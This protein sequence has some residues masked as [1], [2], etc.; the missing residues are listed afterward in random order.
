MHTYH[1]LVLLDAMHEENHSSERDG[2]CRGEYSWATD[3][4]LGSIDGG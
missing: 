2:A 1:P 4:H 3:A